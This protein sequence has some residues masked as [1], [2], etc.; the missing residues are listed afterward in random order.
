[1]PTVSGELAE[2]VQEHP[3]HW[4]WTPAIPGDDRI[5]RQRRHRVAR[6]L[7]RCP[8]CGQDG[9][10]RVG[11]IEDERLVGIGCDPQLGSRPAADGF[12]EP[13]LLDERDVLDETEQRGVRRHE[14]LSGLVFGEAVE[15]SFERPTMFVDEES[16][17]FVD[18]KREGS[19]FVGVVNCHRSI[20]SCLALR[21]SRIERSAA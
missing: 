21:Q 20:L 16:E 14:T 11:I 10:D 12:D 7:T 9:G 2:H 8:I 18:R 17:L 15:A 3:A 13:H 1:M 4:E 6:P 19:R 5:E